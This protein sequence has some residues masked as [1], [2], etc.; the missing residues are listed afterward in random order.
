MLHPR[1]SRTSVMTVLTGD[2]TQS[3]AAS[4][5]SGG[6]RVL[7]HEFDGGLISLLGREVHP[8]NVPQGTKQKLMGTAGQ[9]RTQF[10][11]NG[12]TISIGSAALGSLG[13][14]VTGILLKSPVR[15]FGSML[16]LMRHAAWYGYVKKKIP[17]L[18][19]L[20]DHDATPI[21]AMLAL[22]ANAPQIVSAAQ[23]H[24]NIEVAAGVFVMGAYALRM[25]PTTLRATEFFE[26]KLTGHGRDQPLNSFERFVVKANDRLENII[27]DN[28]VSH[29]CLTRLPLCILFARAV[30]QTAVGVIQK[31][32]SMALTG[33][34]GILG[35]LAL[36]DSE[37]ALEKHHAELHEA[38]L[39]KKSVE[40]SR[41]NV[42]MPKSNVIS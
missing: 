2:K 6:G 8:D 13:G 5:C 7:V 22:I 29:W 41:Q 4:P 27:Y 32:Y 20:E 24:N 11:K 12:E 40:V 36:Y 35:S 39:T 10:Q 16:A 1:K 42:G 21:F 30:E 31:D 9:L 25:V 14:V 23:S 37:K 38:I 19:K 3:H 34:L 26:R 15:V 33:G 17:A 18:A 28:K